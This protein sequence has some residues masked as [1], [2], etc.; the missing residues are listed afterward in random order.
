MNILLT[1]ANGYIGQRLIPV[2]LE[3]GHML[4]CVVRNKRRFEE[5]HRHENIEVIEA[6]FLKDH[7]TPLPATIDVAFYLVHS[8]SAKGD[9]MEKEST[10]ARNFLTAL[11]QTNCRQVIYLGGIV[12]ESHLSNHLES[13]L[14]VENI[15]NKSRIPSTTLRAGI[16]VG[17]GSASFEIMR[18]LVPANCNPER[19]PF[20]DRCNA[21]GGILW[22][23]F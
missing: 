14:N 9:F 23:A 13:R 10:S 11:E 18:D 12:N 19:D 1:G 20:P 4:Y 21:Q 5:T 22:K 16:I 8:M 17:S 6:D 2:L 7:V 3:E 15:L